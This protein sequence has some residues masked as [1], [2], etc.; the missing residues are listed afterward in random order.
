MRISARNL[1][2]GTVTGIAKG[3]VNTEVV[4]GLS[5]G[6]EIA[7][8]ITNSAYEDLALRKG[9]D[10]YAVVKASSIVIGTGVEKASLSARNI[11]RGKVVRVAEDLVSSEVDLQL[12]GG[13]T[14]CAVMSALEE[15]GLDLHIGDEACAI[16]KASSVI[17]AV[18][19][20]IE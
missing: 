12:D 11:I 17:L 9:Q 20:R 6:I 18:N 2:S 15:S 14:L 3:K 19:G 1:F 13:T 16:F 7:A 5:G 4:L 10:A 8:V